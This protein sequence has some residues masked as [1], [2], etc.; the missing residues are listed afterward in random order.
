MGAV[1]FTVAALLVI[2]LH[3]ALILGAPIGFMTMGGRNPG[4]LPPSARAA[5]VVQALLVAAFIAVV[6]QHA[7]FVVF[8]PDLTWLIWIVVAVS[9]L[10]LV[11]NT[12]TPS[13]RERLFGIPATLGMLVGSLLV[14]LGE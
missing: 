2:C 7:G 4:V 13:K 3:L 11:A 5:S 12:I 8:A 1:I 9:A 10:S 14:A 6:L